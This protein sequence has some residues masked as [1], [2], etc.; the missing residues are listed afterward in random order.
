MKPM[1]TYMAK[2]FLTLLKIMKVKETDIADLLVFEPTSHSDERGSF[3]ES[4]NE[5]FFSKHVNNEV[6]ICSR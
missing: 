5:L 1:K 3:F 2:N 4:Y 6:E